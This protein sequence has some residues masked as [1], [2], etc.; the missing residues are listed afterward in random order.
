MAAG[1]ASSGTEGSSAAASGSRSRDE[2]RP[3]AWQPGLRLSTAEA[4]QLQ[5]AGHFKNGGGFLRQPIAAA[6]P[7][8]PSKAAG[9]PP[10]LHEEARKNCW[11][12]SRSRQRPQQP[13]PENR[14]RRPHP[15]T[16]HSE[17]G[18]STRA[19][20]AV[21]ANRRHGG[22]IARRL[23]QGLAVLSQGARVLRFAG[24]TP[25]AHHRCAARGASVQGVGRRPAP[26]TGERLSGPLGPTAAF[27]R[28]TGHRAPGDDPACFPRSNPVATEGG[29]FPNASARGRSSPDHRPAGR[30][31]T[32][33]QVLRL[34]FRLSSKAGE[35]W[36]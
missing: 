2:A 32:G 21:G 11:R 31:N 6:P 7:P 34:R 35:A 13:L 29:T 18:T 36:R 10:D 16:V 15:K 24:S 12:R 5:I 22:E 28:G 1:P 8:T 30:V 19:I 17:T 25:P 14:P 3:G 9:P 33:W 20:F 27:L 4:I 23:R 26:S